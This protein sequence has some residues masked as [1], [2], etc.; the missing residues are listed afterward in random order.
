MRCTNCGFECR[1]GARFCEQCGTIIAHTPLRSPADYTPSHSFLR[2]GRAARCGSG[3]FQRSPR[4]GSP[5]G[6]Q[7]ARTSCGV[8]PG[9]AI[10][11]SVC[12]PARRSAKAHGQAD[13]EASACPCSERRWR[14]AHVA[15]DRRVRSDG[16]Y[17]RS[18]RLA[19][20]NPTRKRP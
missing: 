10:I 17:P 8:E 13:T 1:E 2:G 5:P 11:A 18:P 15:S 19:S 6:C 12:A 16:G 4:N 3:E 14:G 20:S 9:G 7:I